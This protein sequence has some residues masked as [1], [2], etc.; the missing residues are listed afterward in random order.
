MSGDW[1]LDRSPM[2]A[3]SA[4]RGSAERGNPPETGIPPNR[5]T[6]LVPREA[7][8]FDADRLEELCEKLG[9]TCAEAEVAL[10]LERIATTL[11]TVEALRGEADPRI[12]DAA[13]SALARDAD[14]IGMTTLASVALSVLDC[15]AKSG[16]GVAQAAVLAR[17]IRV[18]ERSMLAVW[19]LEDGSA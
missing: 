8:C 5:P 17:L 16:D 6:R 4:E 10:A 11:T 7:A 3:R 14:M 19:D 18:G 13:V 2:N 9:E 12:L 15:R 1:G